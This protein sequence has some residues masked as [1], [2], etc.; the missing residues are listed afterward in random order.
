MNAPE[1][2]PRAARPE[3]TRSGIT[4]YRREGQKQKTR[5]EPTR[6]QL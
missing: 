2:Y 6:E 3:S 4:D 5:H 1:F